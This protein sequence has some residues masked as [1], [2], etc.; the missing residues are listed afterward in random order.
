VGPFTVNERLV[1]ATG[2]QTSVVIYNTN[3]QALLRA[4][5]EIRDGRFYSRG[6]YAIDGA[7][8]TGSRISLE[9]LGNPERPL[10]PTGQVRKTLDVPGV[11]SE[12]AVTIVQAG[13]LAVFCSMAALGIKGDPA[14]WEKDAGLWQKMEAVRGAAAVRLGMAKT[15]AG[16]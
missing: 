7:P 9:F 8:D 2:D 3:T 10:L 5:F 16:P 13:N 12:L 15:V 4:A 6:D 1:A 11:S 14:D